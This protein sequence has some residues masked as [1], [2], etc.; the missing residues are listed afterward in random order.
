MSFGKVVQSINDAFI[1][2]VPK[3][4]SPESP[5][6]YRPVSLL[7]MCLK[8]LTKLPANRLQLKIINLVHANKYGFLRA[9]PYKIALLG[10]MNTFISANNQEGRQLF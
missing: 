2:L 3:V 1:T 6:D 8:I 5:N 4:Q 9:E 7:N 10:R